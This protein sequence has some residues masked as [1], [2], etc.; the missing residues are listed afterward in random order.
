[1]M[2]VPSFVIH[3]VV[4]HVDTLALDLAGLLD[5]QLHVDV[6]RLA[7][8]L[9]ASPALELRVLRVPE[10][11]VQE[12][13]L[14]HLAGA[15]LDRADLVEQLA[16][17]SLD[18]PGEG[19]DLALDQVGDLALLGDSGVRDPAGRREGRRISDRQHEPLL[20]GGG[21]RERGPR[22]RNWK[23]YRSRR[24]CQARANAGV[25][26]MHHPGVRARLT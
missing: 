19:S 23:L 6:E 18:E 17:A 3:G 21:R 10:L 1:M 26:T 2:N 22:S 20:D 12:L 11:V 13:E 15:V 16:K 4:A 14:H 9:V 8:R 25:V 7:E 24:I 5:Q